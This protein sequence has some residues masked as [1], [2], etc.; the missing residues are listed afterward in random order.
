VVCPI[1]N[2][3]LVNGETYSGDQTAICPD[4]C[5]HKIYRIN[6]IDRTFVSNGDKMHL[7][8]LPGDHPDVAKSKELLA[9]AFVMYAKFVK[10][11]EEIS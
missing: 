9:E 7:H 5:Y 1:C 6:R 11:M 2:Q 4:G 3:E 10:E 8:I